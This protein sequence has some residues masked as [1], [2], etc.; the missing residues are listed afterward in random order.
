[1]RGRCRIDIAFVSWRAPARQ[2][3]RFGGRR[4]ARYLGRQRVTA[5]KVLAEFGSTGRIGL[6][7]CGA[8]LT[9]IAA[10]LGPPWDIGRVG[11]R[12]RWPH[13]FSY[14]DVELCVCRCRLVTMINVQ[15]WRDLVELPDARTNTIA[16]FPGRMTYRQITT[17]LD[18]AGCRWQPDLQQPPGQTCLRTEPRGVSFTFR[19][20]GGAEPLLEVVGVWISAHD[21]PPVPLE[22]QDDGFG[23]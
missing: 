2:T 6:L 14:G 1:M 11:K 12:T 17:A 18:E 16:P 8:S 7:W 5:L 21:C 9:D 19:T 10:T 15:A 4:T 13:L 20:D 3:Q 23:A 22:H